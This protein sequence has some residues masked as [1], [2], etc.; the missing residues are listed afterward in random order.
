MSLPILTEI[1][2]GTKVGQL[3]MYVAKAEIYSLHMYKIFFLRH[4]EACIQQVFLMQIKCADDSKHGV[5]NKTLHKKQLKYISWLSSATLYFKQLI[6][7][8]RFHLLVW[9]PSAEGECCCHIC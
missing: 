8:Y 6:Q 5:V 1:I 3:T 7:Y 4:S 9:Y 2:E